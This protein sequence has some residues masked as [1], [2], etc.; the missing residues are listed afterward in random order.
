MSTEPRQDTGGHSSAA[1]AIFLWVVV[2]CG[3]LYG[4]VE[5]ATKI[6]A[7]FGA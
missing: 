7:L 2:I 3:L 4:V 1:A 5:T 6:P